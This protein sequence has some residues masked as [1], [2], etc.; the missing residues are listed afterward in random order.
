MFLHNLRLHL[1]QQAPSEWDKVVD[2]LSRGFLVVYRDLG[3]VS[4]VSAQ[5]LAVGACRVAS[6]ERPGLSQTV[7]ASAC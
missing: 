1:S 5:A 7:S 2:L 4:A 6:E 3:I